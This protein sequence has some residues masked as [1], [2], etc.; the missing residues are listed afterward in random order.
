MLEE[1]D[2][3]VLNV[4]LPQLGLAAGDIGT[5]VMVHVGGQG[6]TIEF[7]TLG[8]RTIAVETLPA[9]EVRPIQADEIAHVRQIATAIS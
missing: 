1:L 9:S 6:Y 2:R 4:D 5:V 3:A 7:M 8:G